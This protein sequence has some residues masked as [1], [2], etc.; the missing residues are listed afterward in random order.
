MPELQPSPP[1]ISS[2]PKDYTMNRLCQLL[3][4][5]CAS[6]AISVAAHEAKPPSPTAAAVSTAAAPS[7]SAPAL[8]KHTQEDI[9]R[10]RGM[11]KA[12]EQAAQCLAGGQ[13]LDLCQKQ[14]QASCKGLALGKNCGMR[15]AH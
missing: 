8:D 11:A 14:L 1:L 2:L 4:A 6:A 10:H 3:C 7:G 12:H 9:E 13:A 15:H 5:V